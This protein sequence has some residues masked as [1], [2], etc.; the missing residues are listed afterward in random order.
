MK[1]MKSMKSMNFT[2]SRSLKVQE[3]GDRFRI[4]HQG[5]AH[6]VPE[7]RLKGKWLLQAG[8]TPGDR[9]EVRLTEQGQVVIRVATGDRP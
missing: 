3:T 2:E 5:D 7:I 9:V 1:S 6:S 4:R 8:F